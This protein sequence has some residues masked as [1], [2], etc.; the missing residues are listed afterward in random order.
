MRNEGE[1]IDVAVPRRPD[2][3]FQFCRRFLDDRR[4]FHIG[5]K[6]AMCF[7]FGPLINTAALARCPD[8]AETR[9]QP[10]Q[11]LQFGGITAAKP[12]QKPSS[13]MRKVKVNRTQSDLLGPKTPGGATPHRAHKCEPPP[14]RRREQLASGTLALPGWNGG[15]R[16]PPLHLR[17]TVPRHSPHA[18]PP[19]V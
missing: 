7:P 13:P 2:R 9:F 1:P 16:R 17:P 18:P 3:Q 10:F 4:R 15:G 14:S 8:A 11:R 5:V 19:W 6:R 12:R